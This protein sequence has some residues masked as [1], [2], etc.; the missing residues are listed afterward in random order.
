MVLSQIY[1]YGIFGFAIVQPTLGFSITSVSLCSFSRRGLF[2]SF[3][4]HPVRHLLPTA[5][6]HSPP[7]PLPKYTLCC[8]AP[9]TLYK[10]Q[11]VFHLEVLTFGILFF[12][13]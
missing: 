6:E 2:S 10:A 11:V 12:P 1:E 5:P 9:L 4:P 7:S 8:N 3:S 13:A